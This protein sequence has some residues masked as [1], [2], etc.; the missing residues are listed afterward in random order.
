MTDQKPHEAGGTLTP[1]ATPDNGYIETRHGKID[2]SRRTAIMGILN[3]TPDSF[4][5]GGRR[6]ETSRAIADGVAMIQA[7]ADILDVGGESTRPGAKPVSEEEEL[8]RALP[9]VSGLRREIRL[10]ISIDTYKSAVARRALDSGADITGCRARPYGR[11]TPHQGIVGDLE[12]TL[13]RPG[14]LADGIHATRIT[15]PAI[16]D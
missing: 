16:D 5:D 3:V 7:G 2:F 4:Y 1:L 9:V 14:N 13:G 8:A 11:H 12:Q 15:V 6:T 10:P